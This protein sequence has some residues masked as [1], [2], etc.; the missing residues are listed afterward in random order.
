MDKKLKVVTGLSGNDLQFIDKEIRPILYQLNKKGYRTIASC[1]G[2]TDRTGYNDRVCVCVVFDDLYNF[3][4]M[5]DA[6]NRRY[7]ELYGGLK[8]VE[9]EKGKVNA[10]YYYTSC[11]SPY[12]VKEQERLQILDMIYRWSKAL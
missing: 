9:I 7:N 1:A 2:H 5:P 11:K 12:N 8:Q 10:L 6:Y 4:T 3:S